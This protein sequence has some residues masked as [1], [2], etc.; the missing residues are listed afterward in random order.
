MTGSKMKDETRRRHVKSKFRPRTQ[1]RLGIESLAIGH[2]SESVRTRKLTHPPYAGQN[3]TQII[4][5]KQLYYWY[6]L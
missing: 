6:P 5:W 3:A 1:H 2:L 4:E